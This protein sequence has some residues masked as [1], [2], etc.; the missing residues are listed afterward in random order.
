MALEKRSDR[1]VADKRDG[2]GRGV[3]SKR[4]LDGGND[5]QLRCAGR[6]P[7]INRCLGLGEECIRRRLELFGSEKTGRRAIV[8]PELLPAFHRR[9]RIPGENFR[10]FQRLGLPARHDPPDAPDQGM[11]GKRLGAQLS[12]VAEVPAGHRQ[13]RI[14]HH[15]RMGDIERVRHRAGLD[16]AAGKMGEFAHHLADF[17]LDVGLGRIAVGIEHFGVGSDAE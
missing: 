1:P 9:P 17:P 8:F 7:T 12:L 11:G 10:Q 15:F 16:A 2:F 6:L 13:S 3:G 14:D 4:R 5:A